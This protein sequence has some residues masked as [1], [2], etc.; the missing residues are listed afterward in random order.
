[1]LCAPA[2]SNDV[3]KL[4][5]PP[6]PR[7]AVP[8]V[9]VPSRNVTVPDGVPVAALTVAVNVTASPAADGLAEDASVVVVAASAGGMTNNSTLCI[10]ALNVKLLAVNVTS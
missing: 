5:T 9:A 7:V 3:V 1:M 4:A 10:G 2:D 6:V 8:S